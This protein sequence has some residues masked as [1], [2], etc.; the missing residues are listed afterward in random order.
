MNNS[1]RCRADDALRF[2]LIDLYAFENENFPGVKVEN[3][4]IISYLI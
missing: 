2:T 3:F 4:E 1:F